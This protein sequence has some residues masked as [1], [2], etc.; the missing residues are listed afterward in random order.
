MLPS[1]RFDYFP[2]TLL[3]IPRTYSCLHRRL[4]HIS[5]A[6]CGQ[7]KPLVRNSVR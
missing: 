7:R 2:P 6:H 3:V 5:Q 1:N 4:S